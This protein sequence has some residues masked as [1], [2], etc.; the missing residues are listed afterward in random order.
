MPVRIPLSPA[1]L[2]AKNARP[3]MTTAAVACQNESPKDTASAPLITY[4]KVRFEPN[5]SQKRSLAPPCRSESGMGSMPWVS[6]WKTSSP[7]AATV[8]PASTGPGSAVCCCVIPPSLNVV[9]TS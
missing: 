2:I 1:A 4:V 6:T 7:V 9:L 3:P 8:G 5:Q